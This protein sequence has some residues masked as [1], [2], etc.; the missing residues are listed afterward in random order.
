MSQFILRKPPVT[1]T[2]VFCAGVAVL[3]APCGST[4]SLQPSRRSLRTR[5]SSLISQH[6]QHQTNQ[7][8]PQS[9][10]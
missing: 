1:L 7:K 5:F 6:M 4:T 3:L 9:L 2:T 8:N 10:H